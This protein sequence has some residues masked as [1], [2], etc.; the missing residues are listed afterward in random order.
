MGYA[1][2]FAGRRPFRRRGPDG[3]FTLVELMVVVAILTLLATLL[4]PS[5][6]RILHHAKTLKC[7]TQLSSIAKAVENYAGS[8]GGYIPRSCED[9][10]GSPHVL[11]AAKLLPFVGGPPIPLEEDHD[12]KYIYDK[13]K[14]VNIFRCPAITDEDYVLT[15][16]TNAVPFGELG[17]LGHDYPKVGTEAEA[18][19][20]QGRLP[21][22]ASEIAYIVEANLGEMGPKEFAK[23]DIWEPDHMTFNGSNKLETPRSIKS[24]DGRHQGETTVLFFD[25]TARRRVI[26]DGMEIKPNNY[27]V[28]MFNPL[29][30]T[31]DEKD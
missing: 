10:A 21:G 25:G 26:F 17:P 24:S 9:G 19:S 22:P 28:K 7:L 15:Y 5:L 3:G 20:Q 12:W 8:N 1:R 30:R 13:L 4:I 23:Y 14:D 16:A 18:A 11:F 29:D 27:S 31:W 2:T 6:L